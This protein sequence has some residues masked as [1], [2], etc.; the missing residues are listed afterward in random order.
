MINQPNILA[1][2]STFEPQGISSISYIDSVEIQ[3][4]RYFKSDFLRYMRKHTGKWRGPREIKPKQGLSIQ[5]LWLHQPTKAAIEHLAGKSCSITRVQVA[6]DFLPNSNAAAKDLQELLARTFLLS[7]SPYDQVKWIGDLDDPLA[8]KTCYFGYS[9]P[10]GPGKTAA[11]YAD[12]PSK[13][14]GAN[15]CHLE[16]RIELR[17]ALNAY[18]LEDGFDLLNLDHRKFWNNRIQLVQTPSAEALGKAW[19]KAFM[20]RKG[21][22][23]RRLPYGGRTEATK[24]IGHLL[25]RAAQDKHGRA[26]ANDL[27]HFLKTAKPLGD[28]P[29]MSLFQSLDNSWALPPSSNALWDGNND[30][31]NQQVRDDIAP[32]SLL[33]SLSDD[34]IPY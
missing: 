7:E 5:S 4:R 2:D 8:D 34:D 9:K 1:Q 29:I 11:L 12:K 31:E 25:L 23:T 27:L 22:G 20:Q 16:T 6:L 24:R 26:N 32:I 28:Q 19:E 30:V 13:V 14:N 18:A 33:S 21:K 17:Q 3:Q 15:C 10:R